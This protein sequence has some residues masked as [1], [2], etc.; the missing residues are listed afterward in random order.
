MAATSSST[1]GSGGG[2]HDA[3]D[4]GVAA[5]LKYSGYV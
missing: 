5:E 4:L 3:E 2:D 1:P